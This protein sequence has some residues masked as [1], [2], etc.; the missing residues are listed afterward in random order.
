MHHFTG[1]V[2]IQSKNFAEYYF[3]TDNNR[4]FKI[5][6][7]GYQLK[8]VT[9][10]L[11]EEKGTI[12]FQSPTDPNKYLRHSGFILHL[13][14]RNRRIA[15]T[16]PQDGTFRIRENKFFAGFVSFESVNYPGRFL[17]HQGFTLKLHPDDGSDLIHNDASF[18]IITTTPVVPEHKS[19]IS[20]N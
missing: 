18:K 17:R 15:H 7:N 3:G 2:K 13:E 19:K 9:P 6:K 10:G 20:F 8:I 14:D 4:D 16:F 11:T 5:T 12:S 1:Y